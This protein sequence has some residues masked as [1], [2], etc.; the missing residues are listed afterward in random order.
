MILKEYLHRHG[1]TIKDFPHVCTLNSYHAILPLLTDGYGI[2]FLYE[3]VAKK[4]LAAGQLKEIMIPGLQ[5]QHELNMI[6]RKHSIYK[7]DY[8]EVLKDF[9][10]FLLLAK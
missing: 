10:D 7:D 6:W 2:S 9:N 8:L 4:E 1:Y 5:N 3:M